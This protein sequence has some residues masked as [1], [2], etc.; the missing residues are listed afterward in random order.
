M[1]RDNIYI[2]ILTMAGTTWTVTIPDHGWYYNYWQWRYIYIYMYLTMA[3][4]L[5]VQV[6][7]I[8]P[9]GLCGLS[10][11]TH[12]RQFQGWFLPRRIEQ[13]YGLWHYLI[14]Y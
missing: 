3:D 8:A 5:T 13:T 1:D 6:A 14:L 10:V 2:Y 12:G 4:S 9:Y 7:S 11:S